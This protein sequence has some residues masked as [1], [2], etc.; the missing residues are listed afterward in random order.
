ML[1]EVKQLGLEKFA[2]DEDLAE[3]FVAGFVT[4][5]LL[6]KEAADKTDKNV[7]DPKHEVAQSFFR[8]AG[9][10]TGGL[11]VGGGLWM[12]ANT[13]KYVVDHFRYNRF[14]QSLH[15]AINSS[16]I[17]QSAPRAKVENY[18]N[19]I[20]QFA[21]MVATDP[22]LL[23]SVLTN[24]VHGD[25]VDIMTIKSLTDL[26]GRWKDNTSFSPKSFV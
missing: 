3:Q 6:E 26:E 22:N 16:H 18:A 23:Q 24:A 21:P 5:V 19:T 12:L 2:G 7:F 8:E 1:N 14:L 15:Q 20:Y 11:A 13:G 9:K 17:L 25:G 4:Q 10:A